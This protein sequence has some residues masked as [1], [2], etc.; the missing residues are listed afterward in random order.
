MAKGDRGGT[1]HAGRTASGDQGFGT[2]KGATGTSEEGSSTSGEEE[3]SEDETFSSRGPSEGALL[4]EVVERNVLASHDAE[5]VEC[6]S[7]EQMVLGNRAVYVDCALALSRFLSS[8]GS[9][10]NLSS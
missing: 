3:S 2:R 9:T 7:A 1:S 10:A 8:W 5:G 4:P 6:I